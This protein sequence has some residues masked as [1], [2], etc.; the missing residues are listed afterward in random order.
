MSNNTVRKNFK[1][2]IDLLFV[3]L[4]IL[5]LTSCASGGGS[6]GLL[7]PTQQSYTPPSQSS[8]SNDKRHSF[9][10]F[11]AEYT[12]TATGFSDPITIT[13][14]ML[15]Y[16]ATGLPTPTD[17]YYIEDY[18]FLN[19]NVQGTHPGFGNGM[20]TQDP[21]P[22][23]QFSRIL[24]AD[25]NGDEHMDMYVIS[26]IGDWNTRSFNPDSK[27]FTFLN[28]G[29]GHFILQEESFCIQ[30]TNC[31]RNVSGSSALT[32]DLNGDGIDDFFGGQTLLLSNN[33]KI[34]DK[35]STLPASVFFNDEV[36]GDMGAFAHDVTNGDVDNDGD[37]DIFFPLWARN[38]GTDWGDGF[39]TNNIEPWVMLVN[40]GTGNFTA[41][42][43][44]PIYNNENSTW[45]TTAV[46][47][48][49]D[50]DGYGDVAVGWQRA[51]KAQ[52]N[53]ASSPENSA[54]A[55]FY[56][57]G[58][59]DWRNDI[60]PLPAN[61]YGAIG[62]AIDMEAFDI[63]GDG[64]VDI[65]MSVTPTSEDSN[66]YVGNMIQVFK[67]N[68]NKTWTDITSTAN[69]NTKYA[70]GN[71]NDPSVWNGHIV[72][73]K[74]DF[75]KDGDLDLVSSGVN[76]YVLLN[77]NGVFELYDNFPAFDN[78]HL[79]GLFPVEI[80]GK[81]WYDF[82]GSTVTVSDT[83][84]DNTFWLMMDPV[85]VLQ[86]MANEIANKPTQYAQT[87]FENKSLFNVIKNQTL[88]DNN[89]FYADNN[90]DSILGYSKNFGDYGVLFGKTEGGG[91]VFF[92][93]QIKNYHIGFG[94]MKS[95]MYVDNPGKYYGTGH[96]KLDVDTINLFA[97]RLFAIHDNWYLQTGISVYNT[98]V[99][100]F[101]EQNSNFNADID[102]FILNDIELY[103]DFTGKF[104]TSKGTT[105]VSFGVSS[106]NSLTNTNIRFN[107]L[108]S[109]FSSN[110]TVL[111]ASISHTFN[112][113]TAY[114][115]ADTIDDNLQFGI[116]FNL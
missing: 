6:S 67:N 114:I 50:N 61:Y 7:Q 62:G 74:V 95:D 66:Y 1:R 72:L 98:T 14:S 32:V 15:E 102:K 79:T 26:Y 56:N 10:T 55:V 36:G 44:F 2:L 19:V 54:G 111:R 28:D 105:Y 101:T 24:E 80:D 37:Q 57:N 51:G 97:E 43:N 11:T 27:I 39:T 77:N 3:G 86:Q 63:D 60:V 90:F 84:S 71:P 103:S 48:D 12:P 64:N 33:G 5:A 75:D 18:G 116:S 85:N 115:K 38:S 47:S 78:A 45:A 91:V 31:N 82:V 68:G 17:K 34:E 107:G 112:N 42:R 9:E 65:V 20:E 94:V 40:D 16:T 100:S 87:V 104:N 73:T 29:T 41:N 25:L 109:E 76:S 113:V 8:Q 22:Y 93:T 81:D 89:V 69:T 110:E 99:D 96:A 23:N 13:Y 53:I 35:S 21:G 59:N 49:F 4:V 108:K 46:I 30:G 70:N 52:N 83:D 58:N 88:Y 106:I 92:D